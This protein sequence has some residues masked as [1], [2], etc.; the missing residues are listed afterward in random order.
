MGRRGG[1]KL[2]ARGVDNPRRLR[3]VDPADARKLLTV[4]G[5]RTVMELRGTQCVTQDLEP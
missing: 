2:R 5:Q 3:D 4:A 1:A